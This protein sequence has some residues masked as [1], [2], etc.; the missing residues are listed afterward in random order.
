MDQKEYVGLLLSERQ[1]PDEIRDQ[2]TGR[3]D[4]LDRGQLS[5]IITNLKA[6]PRVELPE[7]EPGIYRV[8]GDVYKVTA[9]KNNT[10]WNGVAQKPRIYAKV[11]DK[12]TRKFEYD[13]GAVYK[14]PAAAKPVTVDEALDFGLQNGICV[15]GHEL[16]DPLSVRLGI[17]PKCCQSMFG[18]S[19]RELARERGIEP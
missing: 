15:K 9:S 19:Q 12:G 18:M 14:I 4:S 16:S 3:M 2:I 10:S 1:V 17:G 6:L 13:P 8:G 5:V 11:L 7:L